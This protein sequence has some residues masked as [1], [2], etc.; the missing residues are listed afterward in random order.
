MNRNE[1]RKKFKIISNPLQQSVD[2]PDVSLP[3]KELNKYGS[4]YEEDTNAD[5]NL[6]RG[7]GCDN[8]YELSSKYQL[9]SWLKYALSSR[10]GIIAK[11]IEKNCRQVRSCR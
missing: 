2:K 8:F 7:L 1:F 9:L 10:N 6:L 11:D 4:N 5:N 3:T